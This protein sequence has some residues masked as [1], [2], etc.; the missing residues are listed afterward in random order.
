MKLIRHNASDTW[1]IEGRPAETCCGRFY[2]DGVRH[3]M[4]LGPDNFRR[5]WP[6]VCWRCKDQRSLLFGTKIYRQPVLRKRGNFH[7]PT[8]KGLKG[9]IEPLRQE[10]SERMMW[11]RWHGQSE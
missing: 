4:D 1:H 10:W 7:K 9:R 3:E 11:R 8:P 2:H 6:K 5:W